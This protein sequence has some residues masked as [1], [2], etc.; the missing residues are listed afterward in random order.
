MNAK[1]F[2]EAMSEIDN[3]YLDETICYKKKRRTIALKNSW[4][5]WGAVAACVGLLCIGGF[6]LFNI[7]Q[8]PPQASAPQGNRPPVQEQIFVSI[9]SLLAQNNLNSEKMGEESASVPIEQYTGIYVKVDSA[10]SDI[11]SQS[12]GAAVSK[13][14]IWYYVSGHTDLQYLIQKDSDV[15]SLWKF[16]CFDSDEYPYSDVLELVYQIDSADKITEIKVNPAAMDNTDSGKAIQA[17]IGTLSVTDHAE[18]ET[19]YQ[20]LSFLTCYG[21]NQWDRIDYGNVDAAADEEIAPSE[22]V[23]LGRYLSIV[24]NYGNE[25]D[26]LKYTA[27]SNMFYEFSGIAYSQLTEEKASRVC[28]ILHI[29]E[30][31]EYDNTLSN[32]SEKAAENNNTQSLPPEK[33]T[34]ASTAE[35]QNT[36]ITLDSITELQAKISAAMSNGEL[37]FVSSSAVYENPYRLHVVVLSNEEND[38]AKLRTFDT[39]GGALEIEYNNAIPALE[40]FAAELE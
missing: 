26:G 19:M 24:T 2:S 30:T 34:A 5:K 9:S 12:I 11:L 20:I 22:A 1:K 38:L 31:A 33:S 6:S 40:N 10:D 27:V 23:R 18:I 8:N 35:N 21:E 37:P 32:Q 14:K 17:K 7:F 39:L 25:I 15:Y 36:T 28:E 16:K 29:E 3:K 4:V 13:T